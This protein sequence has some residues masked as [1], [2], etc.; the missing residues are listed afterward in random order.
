M[1]KT[2]CRM[3]FENTFLA[4]KPLGEHLWRSCQQQ[5]Q[6]GDRNLGNY[7]RKIQLSRGIIS[8]IRTFNRQRKL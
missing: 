4:S 3:G 7:G 8:M 2:I 6:G 5:W 1:R